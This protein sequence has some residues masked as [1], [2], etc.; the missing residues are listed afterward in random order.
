MGSDWGRW[1]NISYVFSVLFYFNLYKKNII[2]INE[3]IFKNPLVILLKNKKTFIIFFIIFC[4]GWNPKTT[5]TGDV[6]SKPGYQIPRKAIKI[7]YY[8]YI[9]NNY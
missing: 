8:K 1:V 4:F 5:Y 2:K 3:K 6:A 9:K 7:I